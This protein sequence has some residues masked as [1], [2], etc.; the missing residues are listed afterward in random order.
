MM[1]I[2]RNGLSMFFFNVH[3]MIPRDKIFFEY[4]RTVFLPNAFETFLHGNIFNKTDFCFGETEGILINDECSSWYNRVGDFLILIW[5]SRK[6]LL[7]TDVSACMTRQINPTPP[8]C[9]VN[10]A[11]CYDS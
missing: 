8:E 9:V 2:V 6:Q 3:H 4:L 11:E 1:G 7:H 5:N 10:G